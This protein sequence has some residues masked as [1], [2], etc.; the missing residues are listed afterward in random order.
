VLGGDDLVVGNFNGDIYPDF[1]GSSVFFQASELIYLS[2]GAKKWEPVSNSDGSIV[3][4]L[5]YYYGLASGH[6]SSRKLDDVIMAFNRVWPDMDPKVVPPPPVRAVA[7]LDRVTFSGG[8]PRRVP[9]V[10]FAG[11]RPILGV[12]SGDFDGDGNLDIV[13]VAWE[14]AREFVILLGD[15]KGGFTRARLEGIK[16]E[17][18]ANYDVTVADVNGDGRP[19][20]IIAYETDKQTKLGVQ[21]GSIH[22]FLN[23]GVATTSRTAH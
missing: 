11:T 12:G 22:V 3:P 4:F 17:P 8:S 1:A 23:R 15:G 21:N 19:D 16:A 6:F 10:H 14:P 13:Y 9:I 7:G 20:I 5:S 2:Q 18:N